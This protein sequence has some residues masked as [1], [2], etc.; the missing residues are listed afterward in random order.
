M[1]EP[2]HL[3]Q[4]EITKE[5]IYTIYN[6]VVVFTSIQALGFANRVGETH[7]AGYRATNH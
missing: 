5:W 7:Q 3:P 4:A 6:M 2:T 1:A